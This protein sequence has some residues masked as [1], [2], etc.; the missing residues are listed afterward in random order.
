MVIGHDTDWWG[1]TG[2]SFLTLGCIEESDYRWIEYDPSYE[3]MWEDMRKTMDIEKQEQKIQDMVSYVYDQA[4]FV[5]IY[6]PLTLY[7]VNKEI[8]FVPHKLGFLR[9]AETSVT[10]NHWSVLEGDK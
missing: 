7:A 2:A 5:F 6:S 4:Y 10:D 9:L 3:K 8:D 1:H